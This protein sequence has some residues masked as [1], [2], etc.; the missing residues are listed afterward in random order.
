MQE[1]VSQKQVD[2]AQIDPLSLPFVALEDRGTLPEVSGIYFATLQTGEV[3]YVGKSVC[4]RQRW[5]SHHKI[6]ELRPFDTLPLSKR[7]SVNEGMTSAGAALVQKAKREGIAIR[8]RF[9]FGF[10]DLP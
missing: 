10:G 5:L 1:S 4:I 8:E 3:L 2:V 6:D 9:S 7:E